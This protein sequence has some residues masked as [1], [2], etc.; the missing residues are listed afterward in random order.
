MTKFLPSSGFRT[1]ILTYKTLE[2][3]AGEHSH[4]W[5]QTEMSWDPESEV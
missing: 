1:I 3:E 5:N 2:W 4:L